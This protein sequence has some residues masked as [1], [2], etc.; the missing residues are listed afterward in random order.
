MLFRSS[1]AS[2]APA[3]AGWQ[4]LLCPAR[5]LDLLVQGGPENLLLLAALSSAACP[6][7]CLLTPPLACLLRLLPAPTA[8]INIQE[9]RHL[10]DMYA[11]QNRDL[12]EGTDACSPGALSQRQCW[13]LGDEGLL[14]CLW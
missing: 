9:V 10:R 13:R 4:G 5:L 8:A 14:Q 1:I 6:A 11:K 2:A 12:G 7:A 3:A